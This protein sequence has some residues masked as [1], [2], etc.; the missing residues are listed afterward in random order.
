MY[1]ET[2]FVDQNIG[3]VVSLIIGVGVATLVLIFVGSLGG[4]TYGL[5]EADIDAISDTNIQADVESSI[6]SGFDALEKTGNYLPLIVLAIVIFLVLSLVVG[7][8][9]GTTY[10]GGAL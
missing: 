4:Q 10:Y 9:R 3:A 1:E 2:G 6:R 5:V 7:M 8:G